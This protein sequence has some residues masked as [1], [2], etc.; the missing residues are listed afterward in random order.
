MIDFY[1]KN[2]FDVIVIFSFIIFVI[3]SYLIG[4]DSGKEIFEVKFSMFIVEMM[5]ILPLMFILVGLIDVWIPKSFAEK[6]IGQ[7][8]GLKGNFSMII[9]AMFQAG[10][11]YGAFPVA[12]ILWKKG[13]SIR[14]IY[15]YIGAFSSMKIPMLTFEIGFL[16]LK[17]SLLRSLIT[18]PV[19]YTIAVILEKSLSA[20]DFEVKSL[21]K[22]QQ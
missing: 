20:T 4:L 19:F 18:L 5:Q 9:L 16:G 11:L 2:K 7:S 1:K 8:S 6:Y 13:A 14:N 21:S 17:F 22:G 3:A 10:P 15:L 12:C